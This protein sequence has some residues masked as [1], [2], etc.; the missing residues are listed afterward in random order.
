M[1]LHSH[2]LLQQASAGCSAPRARIYEMAVLMLAL[3]D[4]FF[5]HQLYWLH[6]IVPMVE[7]GKALQGSADCCSLLVR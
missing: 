2:Q 5:S 3:L 6:S 4:H 7:I 1:L